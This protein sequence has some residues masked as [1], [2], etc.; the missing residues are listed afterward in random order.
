[1]LFWILMAGN[2]PDVCAKYPA[3][4]VVVVAVDVFSNELL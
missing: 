4:L 3:A 2:A 1:M